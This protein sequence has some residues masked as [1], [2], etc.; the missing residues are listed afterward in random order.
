MQYKQALDLISFTADL[1]EAGIYTLQYR[2]FDKSEM[3]MLNLALK[4]MAK[5]LH[6]LRKST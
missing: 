4:T 3:Y 1:K 2:Y 5:L 6:L